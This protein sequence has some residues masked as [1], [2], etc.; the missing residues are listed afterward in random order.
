M[1]LYINACVR[2]E[3]RTD[4][5]AKQVLNTLGKDYTEQRLCEL[6]L[7][8]LNEAR[9]E[10]RT[11]LIASQNYEDSMFDL[12]K[13][14][15]D[16]DIIVVSSPFW[17]LSF[18]TLLKTYIENI[19]VT[20][21]VSKYGENGAPVGLCKAKKLYYVTTAGGP[22]NQKYSYDYIDDMARNFFGIRATEL[23]VAENL[24]IVGA[25]AERILNDSLKRFKEKYKML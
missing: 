3:S 12:S 13:Q 6:N 11:R 4:W 9:L 2:S 1:I 22:Y 8:P 18:P 14:F 5:L 20:G 19:Y 15:A 24:D 25:D 7:L 10:R 23:V 16:A 21:I 17:D